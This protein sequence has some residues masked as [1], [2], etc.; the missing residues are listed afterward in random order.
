[1]HF[2]ESCVASIDVSADVTRIGQR[3]QDELRILLAKEKFYSPLEDVIFFPTVIPPEMGI[4]PDKVTI[5]RSEPA[6]FLKINIP[7]QT[8]LSSDDKK[9]S[10]LYLSALAKGV[11][12]IPD[13]KLRASDR[14]MFMRLA[15]C[16]AERAWW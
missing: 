4:M 5:K 7:H 14:E 8:W 3:F 6:V 10:E 9:K 1:M 12:Q 11:E 15:T 2:T 13:R 16:A